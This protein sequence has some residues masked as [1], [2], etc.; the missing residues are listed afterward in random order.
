[1]ARSY[2]ELSAVPR[3]FI[4]P[5]KRFLSH[6]WER[7]DPSRLF[8]ASVM[9]VSSMRTMSLCMT[10]LGFVRDTRPFH[11][12]I[13]NLMATERAAAARERGSSSGVGEDE[14]LH[15]AVWIGTSRGVERRARAVA[16]T[17]AC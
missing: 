8:L 5:P 13:D 1:M 11:E 4:K 14:W 12:A 15:V 6:A 17:P 9:L 7:C 2:A 16:P 10:A 3:A